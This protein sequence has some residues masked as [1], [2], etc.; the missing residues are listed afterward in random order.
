MAL[1]VKGL[2]KAYDGTKII[3]GFD[4]EFP[5]KGVV[6]LLGKSGC[7]KTTLMNCIAGLEKYDGGTVEG[8]DRK[9]ISFVFQ[10]DRLLPWINARNNI[11]A[12][13]N[14]EK[15]CDDILDKMGLAEHAKKLPKELS[16]GMRQRVAIARAAAYGGDIIMLDE[17]FKGIDIKTKAAV[18]ELVKGFIKD[19]L[20][21]FITHDIEE[22]KALADIIV[23]LDGPPLRA[24]R[25]VS[26]YSLDYDGLE[27]IINNAL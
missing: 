6:C 1:K 17:P 22:A 7:G 12:V 13:N 9:K 4:I 21:I 27:E 16:G 24:V 10:E 14:D 11:L 25:T 5:E 8:I 3:D 26:A 2:V 19:K 15:L 20:C 23:I 18:F